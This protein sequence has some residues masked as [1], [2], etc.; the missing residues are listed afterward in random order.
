MSSLSRCGRRL[1][2]GFGVTLPS[3]HG[4]GASSRPVWSARFRAHRPGFEEF[5]EEL[6]DR[7]AENCDQFENTSAVDRYCVTC[8]LCRHFRRESCPTDAGGS[9]IVGLLNACHAH[10]DSTCSP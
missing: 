2:D 8:T 4:E 1:R 6:Y 7:S 10:D 9:A 3:S 5:L